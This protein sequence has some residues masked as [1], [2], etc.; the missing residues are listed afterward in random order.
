M[1]PCVHS[2]RRQVRLRVPATPPKAPEFAYSSNVNPKPPRKCRWFRR[3]VGGAT[4]PTGTSQRWE[5]RR[6]SR[7]SLSKCKE[8][9]LV[10]YSSIFGYLGSRISYIYFQCLKRTSTS[11][12]VWTKCFS[13]PC[14]CWAQFVCWLY[15][16]A[17]FARRRSDKYGRTNPPT[18]LHTSFNN[19]LQSYM[20]WIFSFSIK[21]RKTWRQA[22]KKIS[23]RK[24]SW[25]SMDHGV[26]PG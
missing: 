19:D 9:R 2:C 12:W 1:K 10:S 8:Q 11:A 18:V 14:W 17:S 26:Y 20:S 23:V 24:L 25:A 15:C 21:L 13:S 22:I 3:Y 6:C 16:F 7:L 4:R 5:C